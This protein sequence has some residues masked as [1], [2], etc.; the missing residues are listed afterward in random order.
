MPADAAALQSD[1]VSFL[2]NAFHRFGALEP[3]NHVTDVTDV[4][5]CVGGSTG[6]KLRMR[7]RYRHHSPE[8]PE[9]LFVKFSRD[10]DNPRR[11]RGRTQMDLEVRFAIL[12]RAGLPITVPKTVFADYHRASGT[13][14]LITERIPFGT[15]PVEPHHAKCLDYQMPDPLGHYEAL[16]SSVARLAG[17]HRSGRLA[18]GFSEGF[19][20]D[21]ARV[22]VGTPPVRTDAQRSDSV[23]RLARFGERYPGLVPERLRSPEFIR[24]MLSEVNAVAAAQDNVMAQ[25]TSDTDA[26]ALCHWNANVDNA[27]FWRDPRGR[28]RCGLLDWGCVSEMNVTMALWGALCS[29]EPHLWE[30]Q[31]PRLLAHFSAEFEAAGGPSLDPSALQRMLLRYAVTMGV[32]WLLDAPG[33]IETVAPDLDGRCTRHDPRISDNEVARTQLLMLTNF[34]HL[35]QVSDF[36]ELIG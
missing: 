28:L 16:L 18:P 5:E 4:A 13:G 23:E 2:D 21:P 26:V 9:D 30:L 36:G 19:S 22:G 20:Y 33:Y 1:F 24:R 6:R 7:A 32:T 15:P 35:W 12:A 31:L 34:L 14:I 17:A 8:L 25:L 29:A 10:F 27:W 11:D 3:D